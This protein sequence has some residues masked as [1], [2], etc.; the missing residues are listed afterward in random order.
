MNSRLRFNL[1]LA[2][3]FT[4]IILTLTGCTDIFT[5]NYLSSLQTDP[6][7]MSNQ[8]LSN[9]IENNLTT[10]SETD[11]LEAEETLSESRLVL[12][13]DV[14]NNPKLAKQYVEESKLLMEINLE[15]ADLEV[16]AGYAVDAFKVDP[17][18]LDSTELL[19]GGLG[20]LSGI[21]EDE[22]NATALGDVEDYETETLT[23]AGFTTDEIE[24]IQMASEMLELAEAGASGDM[25]GLFEG[26]PI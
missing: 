18:S 14:L 10:L 16:A 17:E 26:L 12:T 19:I 11:L 9:H 7:D 24:D 6:S 20:V 23:A 25:A 22:D 21:I 15:Q 13:E 2:I 8:E 4:S 5:N 1:L 3:V